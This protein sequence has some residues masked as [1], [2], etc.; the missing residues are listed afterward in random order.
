MQTQ[1]VK[2]VTLSFDHLQAMVKAM[3]RASI[4]VESPATD[5]KVGRLGNTVIFRAIE[6]CDGDWLIRHANGLFNEDGLPDSVVDK[7]STAIMELGGIDEAGI[8]TIEV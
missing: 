1:L 4:K 6:T 5:I 8:M 3:H 7:I 2:T